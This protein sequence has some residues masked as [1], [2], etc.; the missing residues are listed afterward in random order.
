MLCYLDILLTNLYIYNDIHYNILL[1]KMSRNK[2]IR[3]I[4]GYF[5]GTSITRSEIILKLYCKPIEI[6]TMKTLTHTKKKK[7]KKKK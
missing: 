4:I 1:N 6:N 2:Y 5:I 7:K 3:G